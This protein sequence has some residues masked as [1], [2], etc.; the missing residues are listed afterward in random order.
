MSKFSD[1]NAKLYDAIMNFYIF[2]L[3]LPY[4]NTKVISQRQRVLGERFALIRVSLESSQITSRWI[5][6][7]LERLSS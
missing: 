7:L 5:N 2:N 4:S 1:K 3:V 6:S